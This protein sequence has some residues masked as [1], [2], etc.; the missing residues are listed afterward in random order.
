MTRTAH[1]TLNPFGMGYL[2]QNLL[3]I[4][5]VSL[6]SVCLKLV[7]TTWTNYV[8]YIFE[9]FKKMLHSN[10]RNGKKY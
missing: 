3:Q 4:T 6:D 5:S 2:P 1:I 9:F 7:T 10:F 8:Q